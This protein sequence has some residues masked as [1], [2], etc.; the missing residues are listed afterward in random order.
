MPRVVGFLPKMRKHR[1][2][3]KW[4]KGTPNQS[5]SCQLCLNL[6][7]EN[8]GSINYQVNTSTSYYYFTA[9]KTHLVVANALTLQTSQSVI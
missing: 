2:K 7:E 3:L 4:L 6:T 1:E 5:S 8:S 9:A